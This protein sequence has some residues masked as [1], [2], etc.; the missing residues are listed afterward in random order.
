MI[1]PI[2]DTLKQSHKGQAESTHVHVYV[3]TDTI[4]KITSEPLLIIVP[5]VSFI[6]GSMH[7]NSYVHIPFEQ[8]VPV[9]YAEDQLSG[10]YL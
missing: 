6:R 3:Y 9:H 1:P 7:C 10:V 2:K 4:Y 5:K 8:D